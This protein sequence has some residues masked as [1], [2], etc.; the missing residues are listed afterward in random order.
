M[1]N[2]LQ[3]KDETSRVSACKSR[4]RISMLDLWREVLREVSLPHR[5]ECDIIHLEIAIA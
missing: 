2:V 5:R 4:T 1:T 3:A